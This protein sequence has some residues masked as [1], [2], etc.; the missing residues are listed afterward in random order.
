MVSCGHDTLDADLR[1]LLRHPAVAAVLLRGAA[2]A[3]VTACRAL[4][5]AIHSAA[6]GLPPL[7][8]IDAGSASSIPE[9]LAA[10]DPA[11]LS[12]ELATGGEDFE[13]TLRVLEW[14][15][16]MAE[17]GIDMVLSPRL[18]GDAPPVSDPDI[19]A[20]LASA[21]TEALLAAGLIA[22][23]GPYRPPTGSDTASPFGVA[24]SHGL[25]AV[26]LAPELAPERSELEALRDNLGA[27][28]VVVGPPVRSVAQVRAGIEAGIDLIPVEPI[29][30]VPE[31]EAL[32]EPWSLAAEPNAPG[33]PASRVDTLR[34]DWL[35]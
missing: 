30:A 35:V 16:E 33:D 29:L 26:F 31:I 2:L 3:D 12:F 19:T 6:T 4:S 27:D 21:W 34:V 24:R 7:V 8:V 5:A 9:P 22:C 20:R 1:Q 25:E 18:E 10:P 11:H 28:L 23:V 13:V 17:L 15:R 32:L 14:G